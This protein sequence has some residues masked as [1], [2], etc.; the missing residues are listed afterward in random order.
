MVNEAASFSTVA[1][2]AMT[3]VIT[4]AEILRRK[5]FSSLLVY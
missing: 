1:G 2:A 3:G 4:A 5:G